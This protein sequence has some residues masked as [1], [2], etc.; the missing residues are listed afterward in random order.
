[1]RSYL[2]WLV[3]K[4]KAERITKKKLDAG[5]IV[6]SIGAPGVGGSVLFI[7]TVRDNSEA[8]KV[9]RIFYDAY[10]PMAEKKLIEIE[11]DVA[12]KWPMVS[13]RLQH[14]IGE[15][16]V[17]DVSVAVAASAPHRA[18]SFEACRYAIERIKRE[19]PIWKKERLADG[20]E[21]WV[22]GHAIGRAKPRAKIVGVSKV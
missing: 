10:P 18:E 1:L 5:A 12:R 9:D 13:I 22:E 20:S 21:A 14:R 17:G 2:L 11:E 19:A 16:K 3:D 8:G 6:A 7:G 4:T 15:L